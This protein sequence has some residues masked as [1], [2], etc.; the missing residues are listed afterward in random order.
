MYVLSRNAEF[1]V[2]HHTRPIGVILFILIQSLLLPLIFV[3]IEAMLGLLNRRIKKGIHYFIIASLLSV[4]A[5][6]VLKQNLQYSGMIL[7]IIAVIA[8]MVITLTYIRFQS[9]R[10]FLTF[11]LP[12]IFIFPYLFLFQSPVHKIVFPEEKTPVAKVTI[13]NPVPIIMVIFDEFP[14][15][16]LMNKEGQIDTVRYS[17]F[18]ALAR[19]AYWFRNA[20]T[21]SDHTHIA[22]PAI[23]TGN[24]PARDKLPTINDYPLNLFTIL[25]NTY[26]LHVYESMTSLCPEDL[27]S[28]KTTSLLQRSASLLSDTIMVYLHVLLPEDFTEGLPVVN[29][30]WKDFGAETIKGASPSVFLEEIHNLVERAGKEIKKDRAGVFRD[31]LKSI[32]GSNTPVLHFIHCYLPH[33]PWVYLPS[34]KKHSITFNRI[35]GLNNEWW[36]DNESFVIGAYQHHLLQVGFVDKL[37]GE[38]IE[39]LKATGLYDRSLIIITADHGVSFRAG[40]SRR[41]VTKNNYQDIMPIPLFIKIPGQKRGVISDRNVETVDILPSIMD[42]LDAT[43][44]FS[45]DG[46]SVFDMSVEER[47]K[48]IIYVKQT[49]EDK[50]VFESGLQAKYDALRRK[51]ALFGSGDIEGLFRIGPYSEF[52]GEDIIALGV[53][54][55]APFEVQIDQSLYFN[56]VDLAIQFIP[57]SITGT[58]ISEVLSDKLNLLITVNGRVCATTQTYNQGREMRFSVMVPEDCFRDGRNEVN[59]YLVSEG[60]GQLHLTRLRDSSRIT[61]TLY[62]GESIE[63]SEG[64]S[65]RIQRGTLKGFLDR[66]EVKE[67]SIIFSG[68]A[69]DLETFEPVDAIVVFINGRFFYRG[70]CNTERPDIADHFKTPALMLSG[71]QYSFPLWMFKDISNA[72]IRLFALSKKGVASEL[73]YPAGYQWERGN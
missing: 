24:Y 14:V 62:S 4:I 27:C 50:Y 58:I 13:D 32:K 28:S 19:D 71:F 73:T 65:F 5:L 51:I 63:S 59:V 69:S 8:G 9:V 22:V 40:D 44:P 46:Q 41:Y 10:D 1:F 55:N 21:V 68:W 15:T 30:S 53:A 38:L 31:F 11:L 64:D 6:T 34:G 39:R 66:A 36:D 48:K 35:K 3:L 52:V 56:D 57:A 23:L 33:V 25:G 37:L 18:A 29:Q 17:N 20:T 67:D 45:V 43:L 16:S 47:G 54:E 70:I 72:E 2:A 42:V 49:A 26:N 12:V 60:G 7:L 61:Y